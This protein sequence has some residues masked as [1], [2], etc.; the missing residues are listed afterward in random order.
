M[1]GSNRTAGACCASPVMCEVLHC[2][3]CCRMHCLQVQVQV[4]TAKVQPGHH[5]CMLQ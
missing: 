1:C 3:G 4:G 5:S 2:L